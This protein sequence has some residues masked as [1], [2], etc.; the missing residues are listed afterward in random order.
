MVKNKKL[1]GQID[2]HWT[3]TDGHDQFIREHDELNILSYCMKSEAYI[4]TKKNE[5]PMI[6]EL[7]SIF[8]YE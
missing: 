7:V 8:I 2:I 5:F 1:S 4:Q 6:I 3:W